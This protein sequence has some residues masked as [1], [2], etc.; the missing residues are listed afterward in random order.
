[1]H[2]SAGPQMPSLMPK[3]ILG[4]LHAISSARRPYIL[5]TPSSWHQQISLAEAVTTSLITSSACLP[6]E[7]RLLLLARAGTLLFEAIDAL[8]K[9]GADGGSARKQSKRLA[10]LAQLLVTGH[11]AQL[12]QSHNPALSEAFRT[13]ALLTA[14][15]VSTRHLVLKSNQ[16]QSLGD[17]GLRKLRQT[18]LQA[19]GILTPGEREAL[20]ELL[21]NSGEET[22]I[23]SLDKEAAYAVRGALYEAA[24]RSVPFEKADTSVDAWIGRIELARRAVAMFR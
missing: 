14:A 7:S 5:N 18:A 17:T 23:R 13:G 12:K 21:C 1:M 9:A 24:L 15:L 8:A 16:A 20:V 10:K 22:M 3:G 11:S 19:Q 6:P 4:I 2:P